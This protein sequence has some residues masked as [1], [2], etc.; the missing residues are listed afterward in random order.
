VTGGDD[1]Q[2]ATGVAGTEK[3]LDAMSRSAT[4]RIVLASSFSVYDWVKTSGT[5]DENSPL[6]VAPALYDRDG[7][8]VAKVWQ[9]RVARRLAQK[10]GWG[11]TVL[12]PGFIWGPGNEELACLGQKVGPLYL[13]IGPMTKIPLTHVENCAA[14]FASAVENV[15]AVGETFN[16]VDDGAVGVWRYLGDYLRHSG[17]RRWRV[18]VPYL[19]MKAFVHA[20]SATSKL[21]FHGKGK[22]PSLLVP[23]RFTARFKPLAFSNRKAR[24]GLGWR[25]ELSYQDALTRTYRGEPRRPAPTSIPALVPTHDG[26]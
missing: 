8:A 12:R 5:L 13:A 2:F 18:P 14:C 19:M 22:L 7:Y 4:R 20:A 6:E 23:R 16:V 9:E 10:H 24:E 25:S 21:V 1:A 15:N 26:I 17:A 3:L 11:L